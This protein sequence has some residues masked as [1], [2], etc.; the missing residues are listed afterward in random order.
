MFKQGL[1][2]Q[3]EDGIGP[4]YFVLLIVEECKFNFYAVGRYI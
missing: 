1:D 2:E 4:L 3:K